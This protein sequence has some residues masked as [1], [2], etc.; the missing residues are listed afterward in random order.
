MAYDW[1]RL[2]KHPR[3]MKAWERLMWLYAR[4]DSIRNTLTVLDRKSE[5]MRVRWIT[6]QAAHLRRVLAEVEERI[7]ELERELHVE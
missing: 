5:E 7:A 6:G 4:R 2:L 1:M 3:R